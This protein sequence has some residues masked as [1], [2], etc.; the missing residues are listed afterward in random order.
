MRLEYLCCIHEQ[1][2]HLLAS[3]LVL[4]GKKDCQ[5]AVDGHWFSPPTAYF[6]HT[7]MLAT[8]VFVKY[9]WEWWKPP[10]KSMQNLSRISVGNNC[11]K[12]CMAC[13]T[14]GWFVSFRFLSMLE[15]EVYGANSPIWDPD[16]SQNPANIPISSPP[17]SK[18]KCTSL[19]CCG[20]C[21]SDLIGIMV[22]C[23]SICICVPV[24]ALLRQY[25][26]I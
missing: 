26:H 12:F 13:L 1:P 25:H 15:E 21:A 2:V 22:R 16:Y 11:V 10:I 7:I 5:Q 3:Y 18:F 20:G 23:T 14:K 17:T 8:V 4:Y 19:T 9:S 24:S 6:P